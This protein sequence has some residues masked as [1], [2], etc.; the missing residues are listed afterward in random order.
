MTSTDEIGALSKAFNRMTEDL[1][2]SYASLERRISDRT[3]ELV[4]VRDLLDA[5][6][7]IFTSRQDPDNI[8]KTFDSV[9]HFCASLA[10]SWP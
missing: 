6:F 3:R 10:T 2:R 9:L 5:F 1:S 4:A 8:E 7:R